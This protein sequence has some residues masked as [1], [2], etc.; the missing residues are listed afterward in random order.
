[1]EVPGGAPPGNAAGA[2]EEFLRHRPL[3]FGIAYRMLGSAA[4]AEDAVQEA[5]LR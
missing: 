4:D 3:L 1:M 2:T 5:W